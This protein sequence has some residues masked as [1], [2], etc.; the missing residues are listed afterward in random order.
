MPL[1]STQSLTLAELAAALRSRDALRLPAEAEQRIA[2]GHDYLHRRL[3]SPPSHL[4]GRLPD[5][6]LPPAE[7]TQ[8]QANL[9]MSHAAGACPEMP[10]ALVRRMLLLKVHSLSQGHNGAAPATVRRLLDFYNRD[11]WPVV[12]EQGSLGAF[13]DQT[14]LAHLCLPLLALGDV[15]YQGYRL[16]ARDV[17][18]LFGWE[19][20]A[21]RAQEGLT[22]LSGNQFMLAY[23]TEALERT[24]CLLRA[25]D[26]IDALSGDVYGAS[27]EPLH[28][29]LH[30]ARRHAG[31]M[32]V[33]E[34][35]RQ[36]LAGSELPGQPWS[37]VP[38]EQDPQAFRC[39]PQVHGAIRDALAYVRQTVENELNAAGGPALIFPDED[40]LL[41]AG[42]LPSQPLPLVLDHLALAVAGL[43]SLSE[44]RT[45]RLVAGQR[46]LPLYLVAEPTVN[47]GLLSLPH[48]AASLVS[49]NKQLCAPSSVNESGE[50]LFGPLSSGAN[51]ATEAGRVVENVEQILGIELLAAVQALDFRRPARSS[52]AL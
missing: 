30:R 46:A 34:R 49:Q 42:S 10:T 14:P 2:A 50:N 27:P 35:L 12:Y 13:G 19:P 6:G 4:F 23:T 29:A 18:S 22:L 40:L 20:L 15:H 47:F 45:A 1:F 7:Q 43:G 5:A 11:V 17:L 25:A 26:A 21:L 44:R 41:H 3:Q 24:E 33:A 37:A 31:P 32:Q 16:A 51:A 48:T 28:E 38:A 9:L 8:W 36:L 39:V 52:P